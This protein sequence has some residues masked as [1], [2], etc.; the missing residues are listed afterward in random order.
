[1]LGGEIFV[2]KIPSCRIT[3]LA[4]AIIPKAKI[5]II[6]IRPGEK[7]NEDMI[8]ISDSLNTINCGKYY[9]IL[10]STDYLEKKHILNIIKK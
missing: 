7:I 1:M 5:K 4:K 6:G 2:P 8:T 9:I 10:P 3:D